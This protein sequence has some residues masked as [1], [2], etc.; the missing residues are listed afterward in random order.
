[1]CSVQGQWMSTLVD[2]KEVVEEDREAAT[3]RNL[4]SGLFH[5][6]SVTLTLTLSINVRLSVKI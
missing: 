5:P 2:A 1:M 3:T 4:Q 6:Y